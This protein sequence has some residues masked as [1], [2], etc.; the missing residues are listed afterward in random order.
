MAIDPFARAFSRTSRTASAAFSRS[1]PERL[2]PTLIGVSCLWS[3]GSL[4]CVRSL[5]GSYNTGSN[6]RPAKDRAT[7]IRTPALG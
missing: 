6:R 3:G 1:R 2:I 4:S 7:P 5:A